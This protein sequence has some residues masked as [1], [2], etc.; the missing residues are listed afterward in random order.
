MGINS[1]QT[2]QGLIYERGDLVIQSHSKLLSNKRHGK[3]DTDMGD[4]FQIS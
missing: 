4:K 3:P 2:G 1:N